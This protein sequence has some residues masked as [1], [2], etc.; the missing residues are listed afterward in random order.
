MRIEVKEQV[1]PREPEKMLEV[2]QNA[3]Q[4][5]KSMNELLQ[6]RLLLDYDCMVLTAY[7]EQK[8]GKI[9]PRLET[10]QIQSFPQ[11]MP[12]QEDL[13]VGEFILATGLN[14]S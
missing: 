13:H 12:T 6:Q 3:K 2:D 11:R 10:Q 8:V 9:V 4:F 1:K 14:P 5:F 7:N